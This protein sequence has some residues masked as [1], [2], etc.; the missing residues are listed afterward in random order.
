MEDKKKIQYEYLSINVKSK[1]EPMVMD[2]YENFGWKIISSSALTDKEDYYIN[3][4]GTNG[5]KLVNIKFKRDRKINN[6]EKLNILQK[7]CEEAFKKIDKL[8]KEPHSKGTMYAL[9]VGLLGCVFLAISV[10]IISGEREIGIIDYV[11]STPIGIVGLV[12]W[13][14]AY[15]R[16]VKTK[17]KLEEKNRPIIENLNEEIYNACEEAQ[18]LIGE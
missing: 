13:I 15:F 1:L 4:I 12:C 11:I 9:M 18:K 10:F 7:K 6:K 16:Y 17:D 3:N 2:T 8:E 14:L 5:E